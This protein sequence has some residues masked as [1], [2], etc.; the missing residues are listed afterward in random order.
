MQ[1]PARVPAATRQTCTRL[2]PKSPPRESGTVAKCSNYVL[3]G[4]RALARGWIA[5]ARD[6][7]AAIRLSKEIEAAGRPPIPEE[8]AQLLRFVGLVATELAQNSF[9][10]SKTT[11]YRDG[12]EEIGR[13]L[14]DA[15][16]VGRKCGPAS[17]DAVRPLHARE[18][19]SG[20]VAR[21]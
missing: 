14:A 3:D 2:T 5:R 19:C 6:N 1:A 13:D 9:P 7:I 17:G 12:W 20:A 21:R 18:R 8:Q 11:G 4:D 16:T 10:L 15:V